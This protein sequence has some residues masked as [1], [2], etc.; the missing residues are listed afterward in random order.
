MA[1]SLYDQ[2]ASASAEE[3]EAWVKSLPDHVVENLHRQ[4]WW[5]I[6]RPEQQ[7]PEGDWS[8]WLIMS[9]RG[10]GKTRT[11]S[12]VLVEQVL[13]NPTAPDGAPTEWAIIAETFGDCRTVCVEGPSGV[14]RVLKR[15]GLQEDRDFVYN[16]SSWQINLATGQ[17]I[18]MFGADD[19]DAGRGFNLSG[20]WADELAKWKYPYETWTEGIALALRIGK[21]PRA[22]VTT[23]PKPIRLL[24]EWTTR[25]DGSIKITT[26]SMYDNSKNL[27]EAALRELALRYEGTRL[28]RQ[29]LY[30]ELL[31]DVE[32][33]LWTRSIIEEARVT[34][35]PN[36]IRVVVAIDPAVTS[37]E[38]SDETGI[39]VAGMTAN[40]HF[41]VLADR[42]CRATPDAWAKIAVEAYREFKA[43][44]IIGEANNGGD[45]IG[46]LLKQ[47]DNSVGY[48]KVT[49]T[50]GKKV[51]AEPISALYEQGR[52]HHVGG[53]PELED[54]MVSWTPE[55]D[56]SPDR[57]DA[58]VW[59]LSELSNGGSAM[60]SLA[61]LANFCPSPKCGR[62]VMKRMSVCPYCG[63]QI[64]GEN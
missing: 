8:I 54:Q 63:T 31:E 32:G 45:M 21:N 62:P 25:T 41:Y 18:H 1:Q 15:L 52:V 46:L 2:V 7:T 10:W 33:A 23:T 4:P 51:R 12:E 24:R 9:G 19:P 38:D 56:A 36:L 13:S 17:R 61:G 22:I 26:G 40:S 14:L 39:V 53:F 55:S 16:R 59:A 27:S 11:G 3:Q 64:T 20:V 6:G 48:K 50:R 60:M 30:G 29:E 58:L 47:V 44:R 57:M 34:F 43:D 37:G 35:A 28:G 42:T 5:Y 49:A